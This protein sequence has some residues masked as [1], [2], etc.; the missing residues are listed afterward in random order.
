[1][2]GVEDTK[3]I[4]GSWSVIRRFCSQGVCL[5]IVVDFQRH[6][7]KSELRLDDRFTIYSL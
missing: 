1:M 3:S 6:S 5:Q 2:E 4:N 7:F